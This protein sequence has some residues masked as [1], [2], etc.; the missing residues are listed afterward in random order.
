MNTL[1]I[2]LSSLL[3]QLLISIVTSLGKPFQYVNKTTLTYTQAYA[4]T[5]A[6]IV[7]YGH[8]LQMTANQHN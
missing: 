2:Y 1:L 6:L 3:V 5:C 8:N 7:T 4:H